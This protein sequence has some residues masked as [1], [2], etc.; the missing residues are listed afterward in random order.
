MRQIQF[1]NVIFVL[2]ILLASS[3][4]TVARRDA[5]TNSVLG[6]TSD[7][8]HMYQR[9]KKNRRVFVQR[10]Q[11]DVIQTVRGGQVANTLPN[12][13][14]G[15]I[16][17]AII[18]KVFKEGLNAA[19]IKFPAGLGACIG[20]FFFLISLEFVSPSMATSVFQALSPGSALLAKWLPVMF[21]P[22]LV[23]LPLSPPIGGVSDVSTREKRIL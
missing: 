18:E 22:G 10:Q 19:D 16:V 11:T 7:V 5:S 13:I 12:A 1:P 8:T 23:M 9:S 20:L 17:M 3:V 2:F 6:V 15:S 21:V 4:G 14:L